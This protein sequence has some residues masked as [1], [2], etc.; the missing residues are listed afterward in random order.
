[1]IKNLLTLAITSILIT[2]CGSEL[3]KPYEKEKE[4][5]EES[6]TS[7]AVAS[8]ELELLKKMWSQSVRTDRYIW[9]WVINTPDYNYEQARALCTSFGFDFPGADMLAEADANTELFEQTTSVGGGPLYFLL[10]DPDSKGFLIVCTK[11]SP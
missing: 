6:E 7:H 10:N 9:A 11:K 1:M 8:A 5:R 2:A 4:K 3:D